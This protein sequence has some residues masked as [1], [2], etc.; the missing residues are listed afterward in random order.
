M[1]SQQSIDKEKGYPGRGN[2]VVT[3]TDWGLFRGAIVVDLNKG[4]KLNGDNYDIWHQK[5]QYILEEQDVLE[6]FNHTVNELEHGTSVQHRRDL[7]VYQA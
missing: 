2:N 4:E 7:E 5:I 1:T 6:T 3:L